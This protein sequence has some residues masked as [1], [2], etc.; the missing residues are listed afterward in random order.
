MTVPTVPPS[1]RANTLAIDIGTSNVRAGIFNPEG[2][3]LGFSRDEINSLEPFPGWQEENP[4]EVFEKTL[5]CAR[6]TVKHSGCKP[7]EIRGISLSAQMHSICAVDKDGKILLNLVTGI[8]GRAGKASEEISHKIP[9]SEIY[10]KTGCPPISCYSLSKIIWF[11]DKKPE[12]F[13]KTHFFLSAKDYFTYRLF[14][15]PLIDKSTASGSGLLNIEKLQWDKEML[16]LAGIDKEMLP[17]LQDENTIIGEIPENFAQ[18]VGVDEQTPLIIGASDGALSS[19]GLGALSRNEFALNLG[20]SGALRIIVPKPFF[21]PKMRLFC[22]YFG[23]NQWLVGGAINNAGLPIKWVLNNFYCKTSERKIGKQKGYSILDREAEDV[24]PGSEGLLVIPFFSGERFPVR[25][26]R[27]RGM[28]HGLDYHHTRGHIS[29]A[30][31]EGVGFVFKKIMEIM[32]KNKFNPARIGV[33]GGG[34]KSRVWVSIIADI[35]EKPLYITSVPEASLIGAAVLGDA[36]LG[37]C[38]NPDFNLL[39]KSAEK[40]VSTTEIF[41]PEKKNSRIYKKQYKL[42]WEVYKTD[43]LSLHEVE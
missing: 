38:K 6:L 5:N 10:H 33:G 28:L 16:E 2:K 14:G 25:D 1:S 35:L 23:F 27:V 24:P 26:F 19:L 4:A 7:E 29:R 3:S 12:L 22:Y 43:K 9:A 34:S 15:T 36:V 17:H 30:S 40:I 31:M 41:N 8:D 13:N 37:R 42:F 20:S 32:V 18:F 11:K 39:K 21:D